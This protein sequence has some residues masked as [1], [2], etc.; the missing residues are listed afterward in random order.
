MKMDASSFAKLFEGL[1]MGGSISKNSNEMTLAGIRGSRADVYL[2]EVD[3]LEI[4]KRNLEP[5]KYRCTIVQLFKGKLMAFQATTLPGAYYTV[6]PMG[7]EGAARLMNGRWILRRGLHNGNP[8]LVQGGVMLIMRDTD[9]DYN[10]DWDTDYFQAG[11][12]FG[13]NNHAG[14]GTD[15][16]G[17]WSA[18]C[19]VVRGSFT[20]GYSLSWQ[21]EQWKIYK[22]RAYS[23]LNQSYNY[24]LV[25]YDWLERCVV[26][27]ETICMY[28]SSGDLVKNIQSKLGLKADGSYGEFTTREVMKFQ[29]KNAIQPNGCCGPQTLGAMG[30]KV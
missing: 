18:G 17:K 1:K 16:I 21:S 27:S 20:N 10:M 30:L 12:W 15:S 8:A 7:P 4:T 29:R 24:V 6:N 19:Q 5:D 28:G 23:S 2:K 9:K 22:N 25:P 11:N 3:S 26:N 14:G 13:I